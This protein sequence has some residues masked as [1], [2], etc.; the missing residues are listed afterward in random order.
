[1]HVLDNP[2]AV[3]PKNYYPMMSE[4]EKLGK[5]ASFKIHDNRFWHGA[6]IGAL[7]KYLEKPQISKYVYLSV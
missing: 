3:M 7:S 6:K 5:A 2:K 4:L 1:M